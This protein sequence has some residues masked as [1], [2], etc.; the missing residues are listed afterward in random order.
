MAIAVLP[1]RRGKPSAWLRLGMMAITSSALSMGALYG[2]RSSLAFFRS[3]ALYLDGQRR[4]QLHLR[5][6]Y[7]P[8]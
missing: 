4:P 5:V 2:C 8:G 6:R 3:T 1:V 7:V